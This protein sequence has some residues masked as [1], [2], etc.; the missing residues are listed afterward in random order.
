MSGLINANS[1]AKEFEVSLSRELHL[2]AEPLIQRAVKDFE[3][4]CRR[5]VGY[6]VISLLERYSIRDMGTHIEI[7]VERKGD[8]AP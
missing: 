5:K 1:L 2:A 3:A 7:R 6:F 8:G 4:E